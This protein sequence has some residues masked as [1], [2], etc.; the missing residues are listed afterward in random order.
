MKLLVILCGLLAIATARSIGENRDE[1]I[2]PIRRETF[3]TKLDHFSPQD[4]RTVTFVII[5]I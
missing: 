1:D 4:G 3:V 2:A 5:F